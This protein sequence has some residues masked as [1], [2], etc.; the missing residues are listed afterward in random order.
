METTG[1][2]PLHIDLRFVGV[3][4]PGTG[5]WTGAMAAALVL[6]TLQLGVRFAGRA[7]VGHGLV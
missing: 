1:L 4:L 3:P 7:L 2:D 6:K 5:A